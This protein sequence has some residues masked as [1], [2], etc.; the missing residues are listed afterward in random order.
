MF[1]DL[2]R[3]FP[4][5]EPLQLTVATLSSARFSRLNPDAVGL[6]L[7][8]VAETVTPKLA[9]DFAAATGDDPARYAAEGNLA[10]PLLVARLSLPLLKEMMLEPRLHL[11]I[12]RMVHGSQTFRW[13]EPLRVGQTLRFE[14]S[15]ARIE[16][17]RAGERLTL[18]GTAWHEERA[19]GEAITELI[20]RGRKG[21]KKG[22]KKPATEPEGPELC[23][24]PLPTAEDAALRYAEASGDH[25]LIHKSPLAARLA[26]LPRPILHGMCT[27]AHATA[28]LTDALLDGEVTR[29]S[30]I[31]GRFVAPAFPGET[32]TLIGR[33][34]DEPGRAAFEVHNEKGRAVIKAGSFWYEAE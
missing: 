27:L 7:E 2:V 31:S 25:N 15:V 5:L 22:P 16:Q 21:G 32:L 24:L 9:R 10:P 6:K 26:G 3:R 28:G 17:T 4:R 12:L 14:L 13:S 1:R 30:G 18:A 23:R 34:T 8:R 29:G 33:G 19:V 11:N 20:V